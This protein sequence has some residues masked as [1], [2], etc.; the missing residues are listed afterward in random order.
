MTSFIATATVASPT[1]SACKYCGIFA[2]TK[3]AEGAL[4][5]ILALEGT[6]GAHR[7]VEAGALA[8]LSL[9]TIK[10]R[11]MLFSP[12]S[13]NLTSATRPLHPEHALTDIPGG[14][15]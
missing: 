6:L 11:R 13:V 7:S 4:L 5:S 2:S 1:A 8:A 12:T 9:D 10:S 14:C 3:A 15:C